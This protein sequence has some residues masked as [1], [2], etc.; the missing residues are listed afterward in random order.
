MHLM[1]M[2]LLM[3]I[4]VWTKESRLNLTSIYIKNIYSKEFEKGNYDNPLFLFELKGEEEV[5]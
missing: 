5:K 3:S 2:I 1:P 4:F